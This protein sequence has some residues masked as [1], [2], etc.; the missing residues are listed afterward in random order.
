MFENLTLKEKTLC[1]YDTFVNNVFSNISQ[2]GIKEN[3]CILCEGINIKDCLFWFNVDDYVFSCKFDQAEHYT[4]DK[5][6]NLIYEKDLNSVILFT[7]NENEFNLNDLK[8]IILY[9]NNVL[10]EI[11]NI[12][13]NIRL[14]KS[15]KECINNIDFKI[16]RC[17]M[18]REN[19]EEIVESIYDGRAAFIESTKI[20][21]NIPSFFYYGEAYNSDDLRT[22]RIFANKI[23]DSL[24]NFIIANMSNSERDILALYKSLGTNAFTQFTSENKKS[25]LSYALDM[26][27]HI[28]KIS[29]EFGPLE[30]EFVSKTKYGNTNNILAYDTDEKRILSFVDNPNNITVAELIELLRKKYNFIHELTHFI[31]DIMIGLNDIEY[32]N[33]RE[34]NI[35]YLN[36]KDEQKAFL[37][38]MISAFGGWLFKNRDH[39][40]EENLND[41]TYVLDL[42]RNEF[43]MNKNP[44]L[45]NNTMSLFRKVYTYQNFSNKKDFDYQLCNCI[46]KDHKDKTFTEETYISYYT[47]LLRL[48]ES[49]YY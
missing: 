34:G 6:K 40:Q 3:K 47:R 45:D 11:E 30:V 10:H 39:I 16:A 1:F 49:F 37:Q 21:K 7:E 41:S 26:S 22:Q 42:F 36:D 48:N 28:F 43:L 29:T 20:N 19:L 27:N 25:L 9:K 38:S 33:T 13:N 24:T 23:Y 12:I 17:F 35:A 5:T 14:Y 18:K 46:T 32:P 4:N 8:K 44:I 31:D 15:I 2:H